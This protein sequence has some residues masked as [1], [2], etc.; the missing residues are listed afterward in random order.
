M[1]EEC[2]LFALPA[3][4][5][6]WNCTPPCWFPSS[7]GWT[8]SALKSWTAI[9]LQTICEVS[10]IDP[11]GKN[12]PPGRD[13]GRRDPRRCRP[14]KRKWI[15]IMHFLKKKVCQVHCS[16][17]ARLGLAGTVF[18]S[19]P[20]AAWTPPLSRCISANSSSLRPAVGPPSGARSW[21]LKK[22]SKKI[23]QFKKIAMATPD[24]NLSSH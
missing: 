11:P 16:S 8:D 24:S 10:Y 18:S 17:A 9:R 22:T 7:R 1:Y 21:P 14:I 19:L 20:F 6:A 13:L 5:S 3:L 4:S 2:I 23:N 12:L 15:Y